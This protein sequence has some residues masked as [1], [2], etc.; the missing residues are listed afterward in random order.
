MVDGEGGE[1]VEKYSTLNVSGCEA[2]LVSASA[3]TIDLRAINQSTNLLAYGQQRGF[4]E[5]LSLTGALFYFCRFVCTC[6]HP[7]T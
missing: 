1:G 7:C 3:P 5:G 6:E 2:E 4:S